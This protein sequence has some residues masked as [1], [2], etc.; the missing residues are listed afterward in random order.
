[1]IGAIVI[2][3]GILTWYDKISGDA[4]VFIIGALVGYIFAFLE[5]FLGILTHE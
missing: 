5:R 3:M 1:M 4:F 2:G